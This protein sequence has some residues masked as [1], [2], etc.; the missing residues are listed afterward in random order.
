MDGEAERRARGIALQNALE[1]GE[2]KVG[3]V[4]SKLLGEVPELRA[5]AGEV[6]VSLKAIVDEVNAMP[7]S[8]RRAELESS[9]AERLEE[10]GR[11]EPE[12]G[13]LPPLVD[14]VQGGVITRFPPE[15]SGYPHIGHAKAAIIN[16]EYARMYGG[17]CIL[18]MDD[19]NPESE[20]LEYYAAINVGL[21]WLGVEFARKK[22]TSDDM[23]ELHSRGRALIESG[24]AYVCTCKKDDISKGRREMR[25]C[26]CSSRDAA[27]HGRRWEKMFSSYHAGEAI[28]RFRGDMSSANT[29][30]RDPSL[31]RII[32]ARHP[33]LGA[34]HRVWPS[35]DFAVAVEDSLDG[36]THAFRSKEYEL[37]GEL[38]ASLLGAL[39]MRRPEM[40]VFSRLEFEGMPVSKRAI[41]P[42]IEGG[43]VS[44]YDDPRLPTLEAMRRRGIVPAAIRAFVLSLGFTKA[45][46]MAPFGALEAINRTEIDAS[47]PRL[48]MVRNA[49]E[50]RVGGLP[51]GEVT[52]RNHPTAALGERTVSLGDGTLLLGGD[53]VGEET[54]SLWLI[55][56]G[57]IEV[58][59]EGGALRGTYVDDDIGAGNA[60]VQ[61]V[62]KAGA[63]GI[64]IAVPGPLFKD[65]QYNAESLT[66]E[67]G[68]V[69]ARWASLDE[70]DTVQFVRYG[71]CRK[72]ARSQAIFTHR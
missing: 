29:T 23:D 26:A 24:G 27:D 40:A 64:S 33:I 17:S 61:W 54:R 38:Y 2:T 3:I 67:S 11:S 8:A 48:H 6:S 41:R 46:T 53:D 4:M 50:I 51:S 70:G 12:R 69:E 47:C 66:E 35:Y 10:A 65:G 19:T 32:D 43:A 7:E 60:K 37:R 20:R 30:M 18:R 55:G 31:F 28:V 58:M 39:G 71:Y 68:S 34:A 72:D 15:P 62:P 25:A 13:A 57:N 21:E 56:L 42:L 44:W 59:R 16:H 36:V 49:Q 63:I 1:H 9:H 5:R 45:D 22:N 52:L 14:A